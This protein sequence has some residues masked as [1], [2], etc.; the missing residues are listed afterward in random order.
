MV[1]FAIS[2]IARTIIS[3]ILFSGLLINTGSVVIAFTGYLFSWILVA[4]LFDYKMA[5]RISTIDQKTVTFQSIYLIARQSLPLGNAGFLSMSTISFG[6]CSALNT[7]L[8][9]VIRTKPIRRLVHVLKAASIVTLN[10]PPYY[11]VDFLF[12]VV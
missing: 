9:V 1:L 8:R 11:M 10:E 5:K 2:M 4:G 3:S 6:C 7:V 12:V